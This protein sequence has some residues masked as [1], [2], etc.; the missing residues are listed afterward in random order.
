L[1]FGEYLVSAGYG[2]RERA[3]AT[4]KTQLSANV[5]R[6]DDGYAT[7]FYDGSEDIER[8]QPAHLAPGFDPGTLNIYLR[9]ATRF[10]IRGQVLPVVAGTKVIL[11]PKGSDLAEAD[12]FTQANTNG[13]FEIRGIGPGSYLL[14]ATAA[15]G[16]LSSDV[17][18]V[19]VTDADIDGVRLAL[20]QT[21]QVS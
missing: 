21:L 15:D 8:A 19:H 18:A 7:I 10:R 11:A 2:D 16:A 1:N 13:S 4:G 3:A 9:E 6:A 5:S 14:L 17:I 20:E 12:Y